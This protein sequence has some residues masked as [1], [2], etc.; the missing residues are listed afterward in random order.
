MLRGRFERE[1]ERRYADV[2]FEVPSGARQ[3]HLRYSYSDRIGHDP[4][5]V[6]GNTLD[7]GLF[8][9]RGTA[10]GSPGFRGWSGSDKTEL[11]VD[12]DGL[13]AQYAE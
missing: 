13:V 5:L 1:H 4:S 2:P 12:E 7:I 3:L 6:G 11:T 10:P 9:E 8:D